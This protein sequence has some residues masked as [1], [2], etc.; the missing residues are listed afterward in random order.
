M[1][2]CQKLGKATIERIEAE[3]LLLDLSHGGARTMAEAAAFAKRPLVISHT[4][5]A[6]A[7]PTIRATPTTR[8]SRRW[9][10][11]A[12]WSASISCRS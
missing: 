8:R 11:R 4:G 12:G 1:P 6:G 5:G 2:A 10:T 9:P 7:R 3:K